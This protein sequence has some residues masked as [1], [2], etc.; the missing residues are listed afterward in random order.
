LENKPATSLREIFEFVKKLN[1][2]HHS[3]MFRGQA[4]SNWDLNP[5]IGR[6]NYAGKVTGLSYVH[7]FNQWVNSASNYID[8]PQCDWAKLA[9]AQH[10]GLATHYLDWTSNP[11]IA[12]FFAVNEKHQENAILFALEKSNIEYLPHMNVN[13]HECIDSLNLT[14]ERDTTNEVWLCRLKPTIARIVNQDS[15]LT[16]HP[17]PQKNLKKCRINGEGELAQIVTLEIDSK[18]K[19]LILEELYQFGVSYKSVF[20]D[21]EGITNQINSD[22]LNKINRF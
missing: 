1:S 9:I 7:Y 12:L 4:D 6:P 21:I 13:L 17:Y 20:P 15:I 14:I 16:F 2:E 10:Y 3:W 18:S 8:L 22:I 11:F 19:P 5:K